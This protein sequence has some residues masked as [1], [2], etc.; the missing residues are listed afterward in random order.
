MKRGMG[1]Y[2]CAI[3]CAAFAAVNVAFAAAPADAIQFDP[4]KPISVNADNF[5]AD[6]N[7]E[8]G[9]YDGN[10]VVVQGAIKMHADRVL[11]HAPKGKATNMEATGHVVVDS[12]SG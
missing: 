6:L 8:T 4:T 1:A 2:F 11:V 7:K 10:V 3:V 9:T 5:V 12:P